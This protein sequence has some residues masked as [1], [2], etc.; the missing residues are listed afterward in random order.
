[1]LP[2]DPD[3]GPDAK[4]KETTSRLLSVK[5]T[6]E[7]EVIP[8]NHTHVLPHETLRLNASPNTINRPTG[9]PFFGI[10]HT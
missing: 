1:V 3:R 2:L 10:L 7:E 9:R 5:L 8:P 4:K 6:T